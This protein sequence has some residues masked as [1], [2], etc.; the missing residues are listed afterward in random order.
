M[1]NLKNKIVCLV[2]ESGAGKTHLYEI[3]RSRGWNVLDSLTT[4]PPR[5]PNE[6][7]HIF[8]TQDEFNAIRDDLV[9]YTKFNNYEYGATKQ[10]F[11]ECQFYVIDPDG[12]ECLSKKIGRENFTVVY[13]CVSEDVRFE[14]M[15]KE[16]GD[17]PAIRRINH[18]REKFRNFL[19][20][21]N[22]DLIIRNDKP[23]FIEVNVNILEHCYTSNNNL[24]A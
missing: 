19:E 21:R 2:G 13:I 16:R 3:L 11:K 4:R 5:F 22:W 6:L 24:E 12:V 23:E 15:L 17:V 8:I 10:Q 7:G 18:D 20:D 14:R 1:K 9:A